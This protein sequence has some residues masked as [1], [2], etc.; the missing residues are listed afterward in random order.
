MKVMLPKSLAEPLTISW[1]VSHDTMRQ[2]IKQAVLD[3][4]NDFQAMGGTPAEL[5]L[6]IL[7]S[8]AERHGATSVQTEYRKIIHRSNAGSALEHVGYRYYLYFKIPGRTG[9]TGFNV[10]TIDGWFRWKAHLRDRKY[11]TYV[12]YA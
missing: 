12:D 2:T 8:V 1:F 9:R 11:R 3:T 7:Q 10:Q 5:L 4:F 6:R